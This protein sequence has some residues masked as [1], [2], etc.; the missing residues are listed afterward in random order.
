[1]H[2]RVLSGPFTFV[3]FFVACWSEEK[4]DIVNT[5]PTTLLTPAREASGLTQLER[6]WA[7]QFCRASQSFEEA[8][9]LLKLPGGDLTFLEG[10]VR[11][12]TFLDRLDVAMRAYLRALKN[13]AP[14]DSAKFYMQNVIDGVNQLVEVIATLRLQAKPATRY[15]DILALNSAL[16]NGLSSFS[17]GSVSVTPS[18]AAALD[19]VPK[20]GMPG[21]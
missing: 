17:S 16:L 1:M 9:E 8:Y 15:E 10:K 20:C 2:R 13:I 4:Q 6:D 19:A 18:L 7:G 5:P 12:T 21:H 11:L 14:P 3:L